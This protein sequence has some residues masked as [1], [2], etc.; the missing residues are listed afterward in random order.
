LLALN[1]GRQ[2]QSPSAA[3]LLQIPSSARDSLSKPKY[4]WIN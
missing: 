4:S 2:L 3:S 1:S